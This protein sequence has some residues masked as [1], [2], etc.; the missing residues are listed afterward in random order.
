MKIYTGK[1]IT[2]YDANSYRT[3][4][5]TVKKAEDVS[6]PHDRITIGGSPEEIK[7]KMFISQCTRAVA[8]EVRTSKTEERLE[9]LKQQVADGTYRPDAERI[10]SKILLMD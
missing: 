2:Q 6:F 9:M 10:A 1:P 8:N 7:E 4:T 5:D 3:K